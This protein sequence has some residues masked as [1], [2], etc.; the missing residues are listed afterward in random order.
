[1][2]QMIRMGRRRV[3][4]ALSLLA[5]VMVAGV[6][7]FGPELASAQDVSP[8]V[9]RALQE[10]AAGGVGSSAPVTNPSIQTYRP[11]TE[12]GLAPKS[13]LEILYSARAGRA[14]AQVGYN[15]LGTPAT[16]SIAQAGA[17]QD[18]YV[19]GVGDELLFELRGQEN[20]SYRQRIDRDGRVVLPKLNPIP[21]AGHTLAAFRATLEAEVARTYVSTNVFVSLG[22]VHQVSV[23]VSGYVRTPGMRV[24]SALAS[25]LDAILLSGGVEKSGTLR[26]IQLL[27]AGASRT[28]DLYSLILKG[29][30]IRL[31]ML[32]DGDRIYVGPLGATV[33]IAGSVRR[34]GIYETARGTTSMSA[35]SLVGLAGGAIIANSY[36]LSKT[37]LETDGAT[38]LVPILRG[39]SVRSGEIV[40]LDPTRSANLDRLSVLGAVENPGIRPLSTSRSTSELFHSAGDL[41][42]TAYTP[43]AIVTR[44]DSVSNATLV[45]AFSVIRGLTHTASIPLQ[46]ND[47]VYI[48]SVADL[49]ALT[50]LVTKNVNSPYRPTDAA[51]QNQ[52]GTAASGGAATSAAT[53][54]TNAAPLSV[55]AAASND[56]GA[57][58]APSAS[59]TDR[60]DAAAA[61]GALN[62]PG[63]AATGAAGYRD[64]RYH[65]AQLGNSSESAALAEAQSLIQSESGGGGSPAIIPLETD[66]Q[67]ADRISGALNVPREMLMHVVSDHLVWV[68]DQVHVPGTYAAAEGTTLPEMID[69]AGGALAQ[70]DLSAVEV[71]S[72]GYD[73]MAGIS[74]T[75]RDAVAA[76]DTRF[77][78]LLVHPLD[79]I[80]L[81]QVYGDRTGETVTVAGQVRYPGVFDI[82][83]D[84]RLSSVL[85]RAGGLT[86]V[87]YP[88]GAIFTRRSAAITELEGNARSARELQ[89][90]LATLAVAPSESQS[91]ALSGMTFLQGLVSAVR[92]APALG[93]VSVTADPVV[94]AS[95]PDLDVILE[96]GDAIY[97]PKRPSSVTVAGEVLNPGSFQFRSNLGFEDYVRLAGGSTQSAYDS[98]IFVVL[99]DGSAMPV[100][101]NWLSYG[102]GGHIPPGSTIIVPRDLRPFDWGLFL[103][104][105]TQILSQLAVSAASLSVLRNT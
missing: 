20:S 90:Q 45:L 21:A 4:L 98:G 28:I 16:I 91:A 73:R 78:S 79:V 103:K 15:Q 52:S 77:S 80:R 9:L 5:A 85:Q 63:G 43:F 69:A 46:S 95:H 1:M 84:E 10:R 89:G 61:Q 27:R 70:A 76:S 6:L 12:Q 105:A 26:N 72:T 8:D 74:H 29:D 56:A 3:A 93:R 67:I 36:N 34:P 22:D 17:V 11:V 83:R 24:V 87:A 47:N 66:D 37:M 50:N 25:P 92:D 41:L 68:L 97:V 81:R 57:A 64:P 19:L 23:L 42:A 99:P 54:P 35:I 58:L 40:F 100:Q 62:N 88:Y 104:D 53:P 48:F 96:P 75:T 51:S 2:W 44:R 60:V 102:N 38:R 94:L 14:L 59:G 86:Q 39:D 7:V 30:A 49:R 33:A 55:D 32:Q 31:G 71:T 82:M 101:D 13:Q 18:S 65:A